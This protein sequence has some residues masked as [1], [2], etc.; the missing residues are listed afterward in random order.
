MIGFLV[1]G[2]IIGALARLVR[3]GKQSLGILATLGLGLVGSLIGGLVARLLGTGGIWEL[4]VVGFVLAVISAVLL[5]VLEADPASVSRARDFVRSHLVA[6]SL[7]H[8]VED[9]RL[10]TSDPVTNVVEH[11]P[12]RVRG[13]PVPRGGLRA[14]HGARH[15][16][17]R[18]AA[19]PSGRARRERSRTAHRGVGEP[20]LGLASDHDGSMSVWATFPSAPGVADGPGPLEPHS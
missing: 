2:L 8:L 15:V 14:P 4:N 20:G 18:S 9:V 11:A 6:H 16:D 3:P 10:V 7:P 5:S 19:G 12:H 13:L 17:V 1:A